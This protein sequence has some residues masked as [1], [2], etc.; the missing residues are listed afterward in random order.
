MEQVQT[1]E[2]IDATQLKGTALY[3]HA[4]DM[5]NLM[6]SNNQLWAWADLNKAIGKNNHRVYERYIPRLKK[7]HPGSFENTEQLMT[8]ARNMAMVKKRLP[9]MDELLQ[10]EISAEKVKEIFKQEIS[11][12]IKGNMASKV[13]TL[14]DSM[15][16]DLLV[17]RQLTLQAC[18]MAITWYRES[19]Q[20]RI[21]AGDAI[22]DKEFKVAYDIYKTEMWEPISVKETRHKTMQVTLNVPISKEDVTKILGNKVTQDLSIEVADEFK[23]K[24]ESKFNLN[25]HTVDDESWWHNGETGTDRVI[26]EAEEVLDEPVIQQG[27]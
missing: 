7:E 18:M 10:W 1:I 19:L 21:K 26:A 6:A 3:E 8:H 5:M 9:T 15:E 14:L 16:N 13:K 12:Q 11:T 4:F 25:Q 22:T 24:L 17:S 23:D 20:K 2:T 27:S